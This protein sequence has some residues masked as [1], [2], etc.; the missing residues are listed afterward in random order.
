[1]CGLFQYCIELQWG[2]EN[3]HRQHTTGCIIEVKMDN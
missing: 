3:K 1:M 2:F